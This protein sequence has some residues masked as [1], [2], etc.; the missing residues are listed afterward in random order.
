MPQIPD[1]LFPTPAELN[2]IP[3]VSS[4][5]LLKYV[6][7]EVQVVSVCQDAQNPALL[8][9]T[10]TLNGTFEYDPYCAILEVDGDTSYELRGVRAPLAIGHRN[11]SPVPLVASGGS[12]TG[13]L[14]FDFGAVVPDVLSAHEIRFELGMVGTLPL[15]YGVSFSP[16]TPTIEYTW[17][18]GVLPQPVGMSLV[19]GQLSVV[20]DYRGGLDCS[21]R[22]ECISPTG[23]GYEF[24]FCEP[25]R[26]QI[27]V[28]RG[29]LTGDPSTFGITLQDSLGNTS[30]LIIQ[31]LINVLPAPPVLRH[32]AQPK[33]VEVQLPGTAQNNELLQ[34]AQYRVYRYENTDRNVVLWKDWASP[35]PASLVDYNVIPGKTYGYSVM[36]R[37]AYGDT[38]RMSAWATVQIP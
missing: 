14:V 9:V 16:Q 22:L 4:D 12:I 23:V 19:N 18:K 20:F 28:D 8:E 21:C 32:V 7:E 2:Q 11:T 34:D 15:A 33:R 38:S 36:Y 17:T 29:Y 27:I 3:C 5:R 24:Y 26:Q 13:T 37:G 30:D 25:Q 35:A 1:H 31:A 10:F 6:P